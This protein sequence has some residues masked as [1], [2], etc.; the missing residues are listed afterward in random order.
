MALI[1]GMGS[2]LTQLTYSAFGPSGDRLIVGRLKSYAD[3]IGRVIGVCLVMESGEMFVHPE[4]FK[5]FLGTER[6]VWVQLALIDGLIYIHGVDPQNHERM[7]SHEEAFWPDLAIK[8]VAP[9]KDLVTAPLV[10]ILEFVEILR[11]ARWKCHDPRHV[12]SREATLTIHTAVLIK[13]P[14]S[15]SAH[16]VCCACSDTKANDDTDK[17]E[18]ILDGRRIPEH[19]SVAF[20]AN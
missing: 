15:I 16:G 5:P 2:V 9:I 4:L 1:L 12:G 13:P 11:E 10:L 18:V 14:E 19:T 6:G 8:K 3:D 7:L 17:T 20:Y